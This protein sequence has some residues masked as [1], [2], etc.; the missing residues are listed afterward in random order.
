MRA[1]A[2]NAVYRAHTPSLAGKLKL[3]WKGKEPAE[4]LYLKLKGQ[5]LTAK[6]SAHLCL[7][8]VFVCGV[9]A[10]HTHH[11]QRGGLFF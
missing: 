6:V 9:H 5:A 8:C 7:C 2:R 11:T 4:K 3:H 10:G 1:E